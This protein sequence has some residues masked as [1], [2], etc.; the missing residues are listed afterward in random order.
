MNSLRQRPYWVDEEPLIQ[1]VLNRF[2]D[3]IERNVKTQ[4]R[5]NNK[6]T[7]ELF[8]HIEDDPQYLWN[9]LKSLDNEY[10]VLT[11]SKQRGKS[12][13]DSY[14]NAQLS[15]NPD[16]ENLVRNWLNRPAFDP[17]TLTW[18]QKFE[19]IFH[20]FEDGGEALKI[21][22]RA[23]GKSAAEVLQG[24]AKLAQEINRTQ[25]IRNLSAKC[26]WGD[27]KFLDNKQ[28][29]I[30]QLFPQA[31]QNILPRPT[32]MNIALSEQLEQV[33]FVENQDSF[34]MLKHMAE[35]DQRFVKTGFVYSS[36]FK[37][38]SLNVRRRGQVLFSTL[39]QYN[40]AAKQ[41]FE[42]W[43]FSNDTN[44]IQS[45]FWGDMDYAGMSILKALRRSFTD[46]SAWQTGF[47]LMLK[48]H[49][50]GHGHKIRDSKK[51]QQ[52]DPGT[53]GCHYA[54]DVILPTIRSSQRFLDQE[55][56]AQRDFEF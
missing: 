47:K 54:D 39:G 12:G 51:M 33:I 20:L 35:K 42:N 30:S 17:Y 43:W 55:I 19:K 31:S 46:I 1:D 21:P 32:L 14:D 37:G 45:Y 23:E 10:H 15:F 24:F 38:S 26:F 53:T 40:E 3:Q 11:I 8:D 50:Q 29:L 28:N 44:S 18:N 6:S 7:P 2:L 16:K 5:V 27:S 9:L 13:R 41:S 36:G 34:L 25:T 48:F 49:E 52:L 22:L 4:V 56:I